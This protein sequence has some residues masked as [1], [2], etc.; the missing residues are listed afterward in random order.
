MNINRGITIPTA[1]NRLPVI[2]FWVFAMFL[3]FWGLGQMP[4]IGSASRWAEVAR[5][6]RI[7]GEVFHPTSNGEPYFDKPLGGYWLIRLTAVT[8]GSLNQWAVKLPSAVAGLL[9]G[10]PLLGLAGLILWVLVYYRPGRM[11]AVLG[12]HCEMPPWWQPHSL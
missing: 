6:M 5:E 10:A 12:I 8:T 11:S 4:L 2:V 3:L 7:T 1:L 9:I